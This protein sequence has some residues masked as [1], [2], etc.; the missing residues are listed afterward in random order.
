MTAQIQAFPSQRYAPESL[1]GLSTI[2][3]STYAP[4]Q[5]ISAEESLVKAARTVRSIRNAFAPINKLPFEILAHVCTF[6]PDVTSDFAHICLQVCRHWRNALLAFPSPWKEIHTEDPLHINVHLARSG[7]VPLEVHFHGRS[8]V[9]QFLQKVVPHAGR[10]RFLYLSLRV[11]DCEQIL[12]SL[13]GGHVMAL[14]RVLH[15][16]R[17]STRLTLS[18]SMMEKISSFAANITTLILW[19]INTN[20][21]SLMLQRLLRFT[22]I[23]QNGF[24]GPRV[25][26]VIGLI[27]GSPVL[28]VLNVQRARYSYEDD[29]GTDI[30]PVTLQHLRLA[31]LGG[32]PSPPSPNSL[33]YVEVDLLPHLRIPQ[34]GQRCIRINPGNATFPHDTNYFLTLFH[35]WNLISGSEDGFGGGAR[36]SYVDLSI[37]ESPT[38]LTGRMEIVGQDGFC[39]KILSPERIPRSSQPWPMPDWETTNDEPG[40][41]NDDEIRTQLSRLG[42]FLD[43]LQRSPSPLAALEALLFSGF[44]RTSN[45][46]D[47]LQYLR[48]C[49]KGL[50][51]IRKFQVEETNLWVVIHLLRP[52]EDESGRTVLL[53]PLLEFLSFDRCTPVDLPI[54]ALLEVMKKRAAL[55][56]VVETVLG[57]DE[58]VDLSELW[59]VEETT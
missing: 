49:F 14:L 9:N 19:N 30:E 57:D 55:G 27:R 18:A 46:S 39:I 41:A 5:I 1:R 44:G 4:S 53:F 45:K 15:F 33:P 37:Q 35:A 59:D 8:P 34:T 58:E 31:K 6:A 48:E 10:F 20:L 50:E 40:A 28:E 52:F 29:A 2:Q 3:H 56:N 36:F 22:L 51:Q 16:K 26:D 32:R 13:G 21:S 43:P 23:T 24:E 38:T 25:S 12:D 47:Y 42:R 7:E 17:G 54:S 11:D